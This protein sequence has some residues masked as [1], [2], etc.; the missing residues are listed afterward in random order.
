LGVDVAVAVQAVGRLVLAVVCVAVLMVARWRHEQQVMSPP[1]LL[2]LPSLSD[3]TARGRDVRTPR[4]IRR[5]AAG[6]GRASH[7]LYWLGLT[8]S[9]AL[10][11]QAISTLVLQATQR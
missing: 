4:A 3:A 5:G 7:W 10:A 8:T 2:R 11:A 1:R 6:L 9:A